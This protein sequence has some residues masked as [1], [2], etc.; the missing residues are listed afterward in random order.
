[1]TGENT[2]PQIDVPD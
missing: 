1:M 2:Y